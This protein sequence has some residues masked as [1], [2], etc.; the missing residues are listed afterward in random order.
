M[1]HMDKASTKVQP[2]DEVLVFGQFDSEPTWLAMQNMA[3]DA[4]NE[5]VE[6]A[7]FEPG[8]PEGLSFSA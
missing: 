6:T 5:C 8:N 4:V 2:T 3:A 1:T 7:D